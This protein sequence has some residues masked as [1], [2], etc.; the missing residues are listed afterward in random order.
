MSAIALFHTPF[1]RNLPAQAEAGAKGLAAIFSGGDAVDSRTVGARRHHAPSTCRSGHPRFSRRLRQNLAGHRPGRHCADT[2]SNGMD[3]EDYPPITAFQ[4][5]LQMVHRMMAGTILLMVG[6]CAWLAR[7]Q[8][9]PQHRLSRL[10]SGWFWLIVAQ[11]FLGAATIWTGK[12]ADIAT[13]HVACGA[14]M[15]GDGRADFD[16]FLPRGW[17]APA[18]ARIARREQM[19]LPRLADV[20][21]R[22]PRSEPV[23]ESHRSNPGRRARAG[24]IPRARTNPRRPSWANCSRCG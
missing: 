7:R 19:N 12:K 20:A 10:A 15:P 24:E 22:I 6:A 21:S 17:P 9:G 4:I 8:L 3:V 14:L 16:D 18:A 23:D 11:I 13:A 1:W 5:V 2:T